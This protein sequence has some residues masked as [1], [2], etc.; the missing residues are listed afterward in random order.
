MTGPSWGAHKSPRSFRG[1]LVFKRPEIAPS[2]A[3]LEEFAQHFSL[4]VYHPTST[5]RIGD[6]VDPR[7]RVLGV[8]RLRVADAS[9][10]PAV[11]GGNT[12]APTI[13]IGEKAAEMIAVEHGVRR[14]AFVGEGA[15]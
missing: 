15:A 7:L 2:D 9:V 1:L 10:M 6:V 14:A 13:M 8:G 3:L 11:I 4:T 12:N 5:C